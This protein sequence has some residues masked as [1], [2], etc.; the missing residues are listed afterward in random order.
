[1]LTPHSPLP[2]LRALVGFLR[3]HPR[4]DAVAQPPRRCRQGAFPRR[5]RHARV[6][7]QSSQRVRALPRPAALL[8]L[9]GRWSAAVRDFERDV[10]PM[11]RADAVRD[12]RDRLT[13]SSAPPSR[14][15]K[16]AAHI[17]TSKNQHL[18]LYHHHLHQCATRPSSSARGLWETS[19]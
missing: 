1:M 17:P 10:I 9:P 8:C 19:C 3:P 14:H 11:C 4:A 6:G 13:R 5:V 15:V 16:V 7:G 12:A 2:A 18:L